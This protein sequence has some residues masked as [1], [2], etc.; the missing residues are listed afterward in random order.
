MSNKVYAGDRTHIALMQ[1]IKRETVKY[2]K[3]YVLQSYWRR[4]L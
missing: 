4:V 1:S 2:D 3:Q